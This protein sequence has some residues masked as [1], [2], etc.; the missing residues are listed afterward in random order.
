MGMFNF[1]RTFKQAPIDS[2]LAGA[3]DAGGLFGNPGMFDEPA[4]SGHT[5]ITA[6]IG[7]PAENNPNPSSAMAMTTF[8]TI[9][10][11][12]D[13][14]IADPNNVQKIPRKPWVPQTGKQWLGAGLATIGDSVGAALRGDRA[15]VGPD[16]MHNVEAAREYDRSAPVMQQQANQGAYGKYLGNENVKSEIN[17]RSMVNP[18]YQK[19]LDLKNELTQLWQQGSLR[20]ADYDKA[21]ALK[22][23]GNPYARLITPDVL[24]QI[25]TMPQQQ[26]WKVTANDDIPSNVSAYGQQTPIAIDPKTGPVGYQINGKVVPF[27]DPSLPDELKQAVPEIQSTY[28]THQ[29]KRGEKLSDESTVAGFAADRQGKQITAAINAAQQGEANKTLNEGRSQ[30]LKHLNDMRS[31]QNQNELV[32]QLASSKSPTDQTSLAFKALGLDLPDGVH[33]INETELNAIRSQGGLGDKAYRAILNWK[34]GEQFAPDILQDIKNTATKISNSKIKNANDN[35]QDVNRVYGYKV[36]GSG[37]NGRL[38]EAM[39]PGASSAASGLAT[40][41]DISD[42]AAQHNMNVNQ[43]RRI[44]KA[45]G[46]VK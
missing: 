16:L 11:D 22:L 5:E 14:W 38:D 45:Q 3:P 40:D 13:S 4:P 17:Q 25:K 21:V 42:Y 27:N 36:A 29:Q 44:F 24:G 37:P 35:L 43:A 32:Q 26:P 23:N 46:L 6:K 31:A 19:G 9:P 1:D 41:Q 10:K 28:A 18:F 30:A 39:L 15:T 33:R 12:F 20:P 7:Q 2:S 8:G 34:D